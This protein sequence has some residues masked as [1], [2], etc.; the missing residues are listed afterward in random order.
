[1]ILFKKYVSYFIAGMQAVTLTLH[2]YRNT[3]QKYTRQ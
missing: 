1:M 2:G 3:I